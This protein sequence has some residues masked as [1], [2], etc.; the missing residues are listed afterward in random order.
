MDF[1][2]LAKD[3][4][5]QNIGKDLDTKGVLDALQSLTEDGSSEFS[6]TDIVSKI[7]SNKEL[8]GILR[9]WLGNGENR[10]IDNNTVRNIFDS[11]QLEE[12]ASKIGINSDDASSLLANVLPNLVDRSSSEENLLESIGEFNGAVNIMKKF[13]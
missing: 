9:S 2:G 5:I 4:I 13:F 1:I 12:F 6:I 11:K 3:L 8:E 7:S 10:P